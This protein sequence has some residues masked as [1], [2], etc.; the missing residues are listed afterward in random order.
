M[1]V[2]IYFYLIKVGT[3][4]CCF[5]L[6][7]ELPSAPLTSSIPYTSFSHSSSAEED[8]LSP[9]S[10]ALLFGLSLPR[11]ACFTEL[12]SNAPSTACSWE[13]QSLSFRELV[14]GSY[15]AKAT[16][17]ITNIIIDFFLKSVFCISNSISNN[18]VQY[19]GDYTMKAIRSIS[20]GIKKIVH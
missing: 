17:S 3:C 16:F 9:P 2:W 1:P 8:F 5:Q 15:A 12:G 13:G 6:F 20:V 10:R 7:G 11:R 18:Q 4:G 14:L 19:S